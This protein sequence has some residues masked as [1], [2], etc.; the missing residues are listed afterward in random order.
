MLGKYFATSKSVCC[1]DKQR[2][3]PENNT[4]R[5]CPPSSAETSG[6][7]STTSVSI[8]DQAFAKCVEVAKDFGFADAPPV[9]LAARRVRQ[10]K[11]FGPAFFPRQLFPHRIRHELGRGEVA[12][13]R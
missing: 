1:D 13:P 5:A 2:T 7:A 4:S 8:T 6:F 10:P 3:L 12:R 9:H 11:E